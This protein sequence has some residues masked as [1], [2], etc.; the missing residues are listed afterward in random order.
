MES[1]QMPAV[2]TYL[3]KQIYQWSGAVVSESANRISHSIENAVNIFS[4]NLYTVKIDMKIERI[5]AH[6]ISSNI[7]L[8]YHCIRSRSHPIEFNQIYCYSIIECIILRS[9]F[10][11]DRQ[12]FEFQYS[13]ELMSPLYEINLIATQRKMLYFLSFE[14]RSSP[15]ETCIWTM[16]KR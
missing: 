10:L 14:M 2:E 7:S 5:S 4:N 9:R 11:I 3:Q 6:D 13:V 12:W 8:S 15:F 1:E 16:S